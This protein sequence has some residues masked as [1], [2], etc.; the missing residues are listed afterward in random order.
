MGNGNLSLAAKYY[1]Q[2]SQISETDTERASA[3]LWKAAEIYFEQG[4]PQAALAMAKR[5]PGFGGAQVRGIAYL[6]LGNP[7]EAE[8]ELTSARS[9]M[10]RFFSDYRVDRTITLDRLQAA[11]FS[12]QWR[13]IID[14]W[15]ALTG[16]MQRQKGFLAGRAYAELGLFSQAERE[17][18]SSLRFLCAGCLISDDFDLLQ[19]ELADFYLGKALEQEGKTAD[20]MKSYRAFLSHF[21]HSDAGLPQINEAR[22]AVQRLSNKT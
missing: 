21:E 18:R 12:G 4:K 14:G 20:A 10:A 11:K 9:E 2:S 17:L 1:E 3:E 22:S 6:L 15:P 13:Q 5:V 8:S 19:V 16:Y 7:A